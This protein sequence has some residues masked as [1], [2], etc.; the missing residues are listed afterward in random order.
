MP[1][2]EAHA[3]IQRRGSRPSR[4]RHRPAA[5]CAP[6]WCISQTGCESAAIEPRVD[7]RG[8]SRKVGRRRMTTDTALRRPPYELILG[9]AWRVSSVVE[10]RRPSRRGSAPRFDLE[11]LTRDYGGPAGSS[12]PS[13]VRPIHPPG[14]RTCPRGQLV[15]YTASE[16]SPKWPSAWPARPLHGDFRP[17]R[18]L[19]HTLDACPYGATTRSVPDREVGAVANSSLTPWPSR[20]LRHSYGGRAAQPSSVGGCSSSSSSPPTSAVPSPG[21]GKLSNGSEPPT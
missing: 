7:D 5:A 20:G 4:A 19:H 11:R 8:S 1:A 17:T 21:V 10:L 16:Q 12:E 14:A 9:V 2:L 13:C 15:L 3:V 6:S 18:G